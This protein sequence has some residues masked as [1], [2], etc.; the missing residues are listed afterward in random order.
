[1]AVMLKNARME[2]K[3]TEEAKELLSLRQLWTA[4]ILRRSCS[5]RQ[6]IG[7]AKSCHNTQTFLD[8][9]G[10]REAGQSASSDNTPKDAMRELMDLPDLPTA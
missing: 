3:T 1:M 5:A 4:W 10:A 9:R 2:P 8:A 6:W 7:L